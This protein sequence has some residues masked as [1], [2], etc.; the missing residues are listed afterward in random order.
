VLVV[1]L[2]GV[3][4]FVAYRKYDEARRNPASLENVADS[5][6]GTPAPN[7][8]TDP[9][10][11]NAGEDPNSTPNS[12]AGSTRLTARPVA[13]AS[14]DAFQSLEEPP[15]N[16]AASG[17]HHA[18]REGQSAGAST[19]LTQA[20]NVPQQSPAREPDANPFG[21]LGGPSAGH[22]PQ[23]ATQQAPVQSEPPQQ[24][25]TA[26][27]GATSP[28]SPNAA[29]SPAAGQNF[30]NATGMGESTPG[31][32]TARPTPA[33]GGADAEMQ[34]LFP[35][36]GA[37]RPANPAAGA[38]NLAAAGAARD[39]DPFA[40]KAP[41]QATPT[42]TAQGQAP[43]QSEPLGNELTD[44]SR[45]TAHPSAEGRVVVRM[46]D[47]AGS[48]PEGPAAGT[49]SGV[50]GETALANKEQAP[51]G[52]DEPTPEVSKSPATVIVP[53]RSPSNELHAASST[54]IHPSDT[55]SPATGDDPFASG[56]SGRST[57]S[58]GSGTVEVSATHSSRLAASSGTVSAVGA[59]TDTSDYYVVQP[60]DNFWTI[61]RKKYGTSRYFLA[62]AELNKARIPD[63][64]RMRPGMKVSTPTADL[65]EER[66]GQFLPAGTRVQ[67]AAAEDTSAKSAPTGFFVSADGTPK[68][69]TSES[70]TLSDIA[71]KHLGRSS[72]W[73]QIFEMNRDKLASPNQLKVGTELS[74]PGDA[75]N[76]AVSNEDDDRR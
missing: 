43:T 46:R 56:R 71:A 35:G 14:A 45:R 19:S 5:T 18:M 29:G 24:V 42:Q 37:G 12:Q 3:F 63:P 59:A 76:I 15:T 32:H 10:A 27:P 67:V 20:A 4:S 53:A 21:D 31:A 36:E 62:L 34:N 39:A 6:D 33:N 73:I 61:S 30:A 55:Q 40:R 50:R 74:L 64:A 8:S 70:D 65:L 41:A 60:Q 11:P 7:H 26:S 47:N 23:A 38:Q 16:Q 48:K 57:G 13:T 54:T 25:V 51:F 9:A 28:L 1:V 58:A 2:A 68:Y 17:R 69:R 52:G 44:E 72:R 75:S 66:Y 22:A 49:S